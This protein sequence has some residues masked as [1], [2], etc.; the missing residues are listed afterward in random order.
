ME[1]DRSTHAESIYNA[2]AGGPPIAIKSYTER[3]AQVAWRRGFWEN[4]IQ[5]V[6]T[7]NLFTSKKELI[8]FSIQ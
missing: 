3:K 8:S 6:F 7:I 4:V 5:Q 2:G 1:G